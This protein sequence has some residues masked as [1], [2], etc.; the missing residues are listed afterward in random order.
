MF[1]PGC[2]D[3]IKVASYR[4]AGPAY[5]SIVHITTGIICKSDFLY[6]NYISSYIY[7]YIYSSITRLNIQI[8]LYVSI[9]LNI[10]WNFVR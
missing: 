4:T 3:L 10:N 8:C 6:N 1:S 5:N 9:H 2:T 7:T